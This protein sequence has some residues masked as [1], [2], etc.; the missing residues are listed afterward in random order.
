MSV[1]ENPDANQR[2]YKARRRR[3]SSTLLVEVLTIC[4]YFLSVYKIGGKQRN[5]KST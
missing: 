3:C 2:I 5:N 4:N 1:K